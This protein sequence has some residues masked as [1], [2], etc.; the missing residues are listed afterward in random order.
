MCLELVAGGQVLGVVD[1]AAHD[2]CLTYRVAGGGGDNRG[3]RGDATAGRTGAFLPET[4]I[5]E[6][7]E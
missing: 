5:I 2:A 1:G 3:R 7:W 6:K 4:S